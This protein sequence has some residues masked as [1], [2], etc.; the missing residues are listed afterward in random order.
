MREELE[1]YDLKVRYNDNPDAEPI[2]FEIYDDEDN[3][4]WVWGSHPTED[5]QVECNHPEQCVVFD[6]DEPTG[7]CELCGAKCECHY[8]ND[9][10]NIEDHYWN[11]RK[12]VPHE[13][14][15][16]IEPGGIIGKYLKE[17]ENNNEY[18]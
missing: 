9:S 16:P 14:E 11:G 18:I 1:E 12:L 8:E 17:M 4:A 6:D 10:G 3:V 2:D 13:W 5:I 15:E 7:Y